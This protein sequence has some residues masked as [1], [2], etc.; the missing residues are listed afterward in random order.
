MGSGQLH[1]TILTGI[2]AGTVAG[3]LV[4]VLWPYPARFT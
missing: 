1:S 4:V 2:L 3:V